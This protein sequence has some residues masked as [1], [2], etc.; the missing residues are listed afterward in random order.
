L[1]EMNE[2]PHVSLQVLPFS[3][4][5]HPAAGGPFSILR[6]NDPELPDV[7]YL[8]QL[9]SAQYLDKRADV[10]IYIAVMNRLSALI[11]PCAHRRDPRGHPC[12]HMTRR[13]DRKNGRR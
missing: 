13:F 2:L 3:Y 1:I 11:E 4:G 7:V 10:E 12:R 8:E 5:G 6:F 9:A